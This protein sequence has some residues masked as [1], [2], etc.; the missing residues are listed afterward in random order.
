MTFFIRTP[1]FFLLKVYNIHTRIKY[2]LLIR[3]VETVFC[4]E[5]G[6]GGVVSSKNRKC[7][8]TNL[9]DARFDSEFW[10]LNSSKKHFPSL[11][12][13]LSFNN[14]TIGIDSILRTPYFV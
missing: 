13:K 2:H 4:K 11:D 5:T 14:T 1:V 12:I 6:L 3:V 7:L 10:L 8:V 9:S